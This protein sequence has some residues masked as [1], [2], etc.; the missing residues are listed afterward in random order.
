MALLGIRNEQEFYSDYYLAA[1]FRGDLKEVQ[2]RW[3]LQA[4]SDP[5]SVAPDRALAGLRRRWLSLCEEEPGLPASGRLRLQRQ[6]WFQP[7]LEALGYH[8]QPQ[9][10][11]VLIGGQSYQLP[12]L[13]AVERPSGEPMLWVLEAFN[14]AVV[15]D[16]ER[17]S[18]PLQLEI[19]GKQIS[20]QSLGT[21]LPGETW[22]QL[23][24]NRVFAQDTPPVAAAHQPR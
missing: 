8:W 3:K 7:L 5:A 10:K 11:V 15:A 2:A 13:A 12:V 24:N 6:Q 20:D 23:I 4:Q 18:D 14:P 9:A 17:I 22:E 16:D 19:H 21:V 1:I